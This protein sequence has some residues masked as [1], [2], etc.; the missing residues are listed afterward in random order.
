MGRCITRVLT[1]T[2]TGLLLFPVVVMAAGETSVA[3]Q[4]KLDEANLETLK[5]VLDKGG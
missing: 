5:Q 4:L 1:A 3:G 2:F